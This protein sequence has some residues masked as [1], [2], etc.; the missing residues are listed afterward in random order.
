MNMSR[1]HFEAIAHVL[2]ANHADLSLVQDF[3]DM[4][5]E[6]NPLF[7]RMRFIKA[8]TK[9]YDAH[10]EHEAHMLERARS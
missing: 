4:C 7:D 2:D 6:S 8:A 1:A 10:L 5:E 9:W 3:A